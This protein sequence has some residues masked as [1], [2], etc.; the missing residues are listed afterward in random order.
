[1]RTIIN[2]SISVTFGTGG[3]GPQMKMFEG[4]KKEWPKLDKNKFD[5]GKI[6][7][8]TAIK[9]FIYDQLGNHHSRNNYKELLTLSLIYLGDIPESPINE[10]GAYHRAR[11]MA[12]IIYCLKIYIFCGQ[13]KLKQS[14]LNGL[15]VF[16]EFII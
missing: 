6:E 11:W 12:K 7:D 1:M 13:L 10:P 15:K 5:C 2:R 16:N 14:E 9:D 4:F 3:K 8:K